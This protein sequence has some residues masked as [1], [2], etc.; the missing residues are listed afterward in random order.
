MMTGLGADGVA[1]WRRSDVMLLGASQLAGLGLLSAA[2]LGISGTTDFSTQIA[3]INAGGVGLVGIG[4]GCALWVVRGR[5]RVGQ[6]VREEIL[7]H[8]GLAAA[9]SGVQSETAGEQFVTGPG[10]SHYH[11]PGC[12][13]VA[14]KPVTSATG[15][16]LEPCGLC[17]PRLR[18]S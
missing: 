16:G 6:R 13:A 9:G 4:A 10:M 5:R 7:V 14:G 8:A 1:P 12:Q 15:Q 11:R 2:W 17:E 18:E 3:W